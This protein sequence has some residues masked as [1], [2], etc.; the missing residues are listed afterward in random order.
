MRLF[1]T[2]GSLAILTVSFASLGGCTELRPWSVRRA[3]VSVNSL[4]TISTIDAAGNRIGVGRQIDPQ[5]PA[6]ASQTLELPD[7]QTLLV[8]LLEANDERALVEVTTPNEPL[9]RRRLRLGEYFDVVSDVDGA[10]QLSPA[11]T[12]TAEND[13]AERL[14][15]NLLAEASY[16]SVALGAFLG[17]FLG[18]LKIRRSELS[19]DDE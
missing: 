2:F 3:S 1:P 11:Q 5:E 19:T 12:S 4:V 14:L 18:H 9:Q 8:A 13:R 16:P 7:G 15:S 6:F 17:G 10:W